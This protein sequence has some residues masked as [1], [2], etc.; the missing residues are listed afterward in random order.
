MRKQKIVW[1]SIGIPKALFER[2][3]D[4]IVKTGHVSVSE[5]CREAIAEKEKW[6]V[7]RLERNL[8][9]M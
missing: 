5:Y 1:K 6:D 7:E 3:R 8:D 4:L 2:L 9:E